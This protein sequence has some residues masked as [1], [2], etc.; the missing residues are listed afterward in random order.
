[1]VFGSTK[2][3]SIHH[4]RVANTHSYQLIIKIERDKSPNYRKYHQDPPKQAKINKG[5]SSVDDNGGDRPT[6][7]VSVIFYHAQVYA[8]LTSNSLRS[9]RSSLQG[10]CGID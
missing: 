2:D 4:K 9:F 8:S 1:M 3:R 10:V 7:L 5:S 6:Q